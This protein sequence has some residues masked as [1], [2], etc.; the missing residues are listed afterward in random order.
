MGPC[1]RGREARGA[2]NADIL[3]RIA[4][5][6]QNSRQHPIHPRCRHGLPHWRHFHRKIGQIALL[7]LPGMAH[8]RELDLTGTFVSDDGLVHLR[9]LTQVGKLGLSNTE[10]TDRGVEHLSGLIQ[11]QELSIG[12]TDISEDG[13]KQLERSLPDVVFVW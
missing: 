5:R 4:I 11:L 10:V 13:L 9:G 1:T 2:G 12:G 7:V 8:L 6:I 3:N